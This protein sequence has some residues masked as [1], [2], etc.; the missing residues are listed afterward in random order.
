MREFVLRATRVLL[1]LGGCGSA[2]YAQSMLPVAAYDFGEGRGNTSRDASGNNNFANLMGGTRWST[3]GKYGKG[4]ELD[5]I[6]GYVSV[7]SSDVLNLKAAGTMEAWVKLSAINRWQA[8]IA[9]G[10]Q[11]SSETMNY[12]MEISED[13]RVECTLGNGTEANVWRSEATLASGVFYH[14]ACT[15][16]GF[17][18]A[19]LVNGELD[20][21]VE[22]EIVPQSNNAF[23]YIGQ[24]GA[25]S[26]FASGILSDVRIYD[27]ALSPS[28]IAEDMSAAVAPVS[29]RTVTLEW[30]ATDSTVVGHYV[31]RATQSSGPYLRLNARPV[32]GASYNDSSIFS[33]RTYFYVVTSVNSEGSQ[34]AFSDEVAATIP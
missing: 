1:I 9:K 17:T 23:L 14:I 2:C 5:G 15:W 32:T 16:N 20:S 18:A 21:S 25:D 27:R 24:I 4:I 29:G 3:A 26:E 30:T 31:Y 7:P 8:M 19:I 28:E 22:Q 11:T 12:A 6:S 33:G 13:N 34:S 10:D